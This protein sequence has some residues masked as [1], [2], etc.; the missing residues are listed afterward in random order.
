M[1][2][3]L[4]REANC[5]VLA[6]HVVASEKPI[7]FQVRVVHSPPDLPDGT[8]S[9]VV[10]KRAYPTEKRLGWWQMTKVDAE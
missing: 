3:G 9:L 7:F 5:D 6:W 1:L 8:Y 2:Y 10:D 4:G